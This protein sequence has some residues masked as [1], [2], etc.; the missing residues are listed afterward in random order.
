MRQLFIVALCLS[1]AACTSAIKMKN[2][3][4]GQIAT[5]GPYA[6]TWTTPEREGRCISDY[7]RQGYQRVPD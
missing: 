1:A 7:Q 5:C 2:P 4:T 6:D 3:A